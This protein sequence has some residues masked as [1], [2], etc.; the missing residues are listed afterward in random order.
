M[1]SSTTPSSAPRKAEQDYPPTSESI[2]TRLIYNPLFF[3]SFALSLLLVDNRN[4]DRSHSH[5]HYS[6]SNS[7]DGTQKK[8]EPWIW[9]AKHRKVARMELGEALE[10]RRWVLM[11]LIGGMLGGMLGSWFLMRW[12]WGM[13][14][15]W[16]R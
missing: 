12:G 7:D 9:R 15:E 16:M 6:E 3:I 4:Y 5:K 8:K 1:S 13:V 14:L 11:G 10:I 2:I